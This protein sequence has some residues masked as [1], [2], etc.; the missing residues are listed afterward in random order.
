MSTGKAIRTWGPFE[1][2]TDTCAVDP[3][4]G[5]VVVGCD[6]GRIRIFK[7]S[8]GSLIREIAAHASGIKTCMLLLQEISF[9][10]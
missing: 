4:N 3:V 8:D 5:R 6:D 9:W 7:V 2:E 1:H 10:G